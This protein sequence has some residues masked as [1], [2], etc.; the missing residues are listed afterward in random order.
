MPANLVGWIMGMRKV[1]GGEMGVFGRGRRTIE[2]G[3][4]VTSERE[5]NSPT[6][7]DGAQG[8]GESGYV[9]PQRPD[10]GFANRA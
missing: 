1:G 8:L 7:S 2:D 10:G 3:R 4:N 5:G 9:Y 6:G